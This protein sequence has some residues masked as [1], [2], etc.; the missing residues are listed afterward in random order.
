MHPPTVWVLHWLA[1]IFLPHRKT[2]EKLQLK[3]SFVS[4]NSEEVGWP[5]WL[6][7]SNQGSLLYLFLTFKEA[8]IQHWCPC[9]ST[10]LT[11][12]GIRSLILESNVSGCVLETQTLCYPSSMFWCGKG[13]K[14]FYSNRIN[15]NRHSFKYS[16]RNMD[17]WAQKSRKCQQLALGGIWWPS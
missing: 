4:S 8:P 14:E 1:R 9:E 6:L 3:V 16:E 13:F 17:R 2:H 5:K 12:K 10:A 15:S 11:S 7:S